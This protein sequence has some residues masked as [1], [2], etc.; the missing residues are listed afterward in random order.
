MFM[1]SRF[2]VAGGKLRNLSLKLITK[3][4]G[5]GGNVRA[6]TY[7]AKLQIFSNILPCGLILFLSGKNH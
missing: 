7:A 3:W 6:V 5:G 2:V 4:L 1:M